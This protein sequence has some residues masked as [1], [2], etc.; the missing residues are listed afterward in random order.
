MNPYPKPTRRQIDQ[1]LDRVEVQ[2]GKCIDN[3]NTA[4]LARIDLLKDY[5]DEQIDL[6]S[7]H[8]H[9]LVISSGLVAGNAPNDFLVRDRVMA[10]TRPTAETLAGIN[11]P[12]I[13]DIPTRLELSRRI[14]QVKVELGGVAD[15]LNERITKLEATTLKVSASPFIPQSPDV[16]FGAPNPDD[17]VTRNKEVPTR[18]VVTN[19]EL[20]EHGHVL[21]GKPPSTISLFGLGCFRL[22]SGETSNF[23]ID[24]DLL[25]DA[26][27]A[28]LAYLAAQILPPFRSVYGVETGGD[29]F[30]YALSLHAQA[31]AKYV[32]IADD[33]LT[34]G[35]SIEARLQE[36]RDT[37]I[38]INRPIFDDVVGIVAF[39]R[40][41][42]PRWVRA[43]FTL[44][45]RINQ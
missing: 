22:A 3:N 36:L 39:A 30:A 13:Q 8:V 33:V 17:F 21:A 1:R 32:V 18:S 31:G 19:I 4:H 45:P 23:K 7:D 14:T 5:V 37:A 35:S 9:R 20:N 38:S 11:T 6:L 40:G 34:T 10:Q 25:T 42:L 16:P 44:D 29:P 43:V 28:A 41:P 12:A 26:D 24:C 2:F 27:W 15:N